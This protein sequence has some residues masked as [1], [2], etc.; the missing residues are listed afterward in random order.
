M[1]MGDTCTRGC[2]FCSVKTARAPPPLDP[3]EPRNTAVAVITETERINGCLILNTIWGL[4]YVVLTSVDRYDVVDASSSHIAQTI[5]WRRILVT[6][7]PKLDL[8]FNR[9]LKKEKPSLMVECL[10]PDFAGD[11]DCVRR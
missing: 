2:R 3:E 11:E 4:D 6:F 9:E 7:D 5:R 1:L 10:S 8:L